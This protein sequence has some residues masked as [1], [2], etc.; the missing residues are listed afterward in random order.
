MSTAAA[1]DS[2]TDSSTANNPVSAED[3]SADS[4]QDSMIIA[5]KEAIEKEIAQ[6]TPLVGERISL[7]SALESEFSTDEVYLDKIRNLSAKFS[8]IRRTRPDGNCFFRAFG[9]AYFERLLTDD[10][11]FSRFRSAIAGAKDEFAA[12]GYNAYT[13]EDFH[14]T[15]MELVDRLQPSGDDQKP[16]TL[17]EL[18]TT[19]NEQGMSDY[20]VVYLRLLVSKE[21]KKNADFFQFFME[22]GKTVEE[23]CLTEVE[24]MYRESDHIH[25]TALTRATGISVSV[26][27]LDRGDNK[28]A[29]AHKFPDDKEPMLHLL[30][31][32]GHYD[33][34]YAKS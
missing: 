26:I 18:W 5:Q 32:P 28:D 21:L 19:F 7:T 16:M 6:S 15:F 23:F 9:F 8:D 10:A 12:M 29:S 4:N 2:T 3:G 33:V 22:D 25:I 17:S 24:P 31:R 30:Y 11:E 20:V 27:Y 1:A 14:D 34:L 13:V